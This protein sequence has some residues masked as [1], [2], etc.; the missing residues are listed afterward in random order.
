MKEQELIDYLNEKSQDGVCIAASG[1]VDSTLL[2]RLLSETKG[3]KIAVTFS[4]VLQPATDIEAAA[5]LAKT[6]DIPHKIIEINVLEDDALRTNPHNRCY[7]CKRQLFSALKMF[8]EKEGL[9]WIIDG[10]NADDLKQYRP[11]LTALRELNIL[12]PLAELG[13]TKKEV[14]EMADKYNISVSKKP[15]SPCL[16]TRL[17]YG[18]ELSAEILKKIEKGESILKNLGLETVR[19][20][21]HG[22]IVRIE[23]LEQDFP[24][25][26]KNKKEIVDRLK[27][28]GFH[29][30]TLDLEGFRSGSMDLFIEK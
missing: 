2:L 6:Y 26:V 9:K 25:L 1:G 14:R 28:L 23:V 30:I 13:M 8:S 21:A 22:E 5:T 17:P 20:R 12:S 27:K 18:S 24:F 29:Y 4:S 10:T 7:L 19:L 11:G 15:S 3:R 16:A